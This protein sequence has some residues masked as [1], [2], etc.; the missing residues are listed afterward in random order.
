MYVRWRDAADSHLYL[1]LV[2]R[3]AI[4][5]AGFME[6]TTTVMKRAELQEVGAP[7]GEGGLS[8]T[9][10]GGT[11]GDETCGASAPVMQV[12]L[13]AAIGHWPLTVPSTRTSLPRGLT[14]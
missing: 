13:V 14:R 4:L 8:L 5:G 12:R 2:R 1:G 9:R 6:T 11:G 7:T 10:R 3:S